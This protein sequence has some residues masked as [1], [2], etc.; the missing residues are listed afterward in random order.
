MTV[1]SNSWNTCQAWGHLCVAK[2]GKKCTETGVSSAAVPSWAVQAKGRGTKTTAQWGLARTTCL[3][4]RAPATAKTAVM[5]LLSHGPRP[6]TFFRLSSASWDLFCCCFGED[7]SVSRLLVHLWF[8]SANLC[9]KKTALTAEVDWGILRAKFLHY[10]V[11]PVCLMLCSLR[12]ERIFFQLLISLFF[13][14]WWNIVDNLK[15]LIFVIQLSSFEGSVIFCKHSYQVEYCKERIQFETHALHW[16][17]NQCLLLL[18]R[19]NVIN[20]FHGMVII[21][22]YNKNYHL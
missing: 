5:R 14:R 3:W 13:C 9:F 21:K 10:S 2:S 18:W 22:N 16:P 4:K 11:H 12:L 7:P 8:A 6:S 17:C 19:I 15:T 1:P 20:L